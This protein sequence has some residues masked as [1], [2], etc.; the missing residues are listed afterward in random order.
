MEENISTLTL[1]ET[2]TFV[3]QLLNRTLRHQ[4]TPQNKTVIYLRPSL[5]VFNRPS[6]EQISTQHT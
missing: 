1:N 5:T 2:E 6:A 4:A 3:S